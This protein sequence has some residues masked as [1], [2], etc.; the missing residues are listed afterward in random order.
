MAPALRVLLAGVLFASGGALLK[1]CEFP[2]LQRAALRALFAAVTLFAVLPQCRRW[3]D[4]RIAL[5][6]IDR[7]SVV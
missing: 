5:L 6:L 3:P 4:R 1:A 7:K 2:S